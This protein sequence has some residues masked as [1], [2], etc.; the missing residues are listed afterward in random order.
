MAAVAAKDESELACV[1]IPLGTMQ[2]LLP[3]VSI[4][5]IIP[6]RRLKAW[7]ASPDWCI[8]VLGWRGEAVPVVDFES[9]NGSVATRA[10]R[11]RCLLI[12]NRARSSVGR[13]FYSLVSAGLPRLVHLTAADLESHPIKLGDAQVASVMVGTEAAV[14]PNLSFIE[15]R[16]ASLPEERVRAER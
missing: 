11:G 15:E 7:E 2:L 16:L 14:V 10:E 4:A 5:E 8:G 6:W 1:V 9:L 12:M 13:P 3:N